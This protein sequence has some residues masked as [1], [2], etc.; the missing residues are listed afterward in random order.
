MVCLNQLSYLTVAAK[1]GKALKQVEIC[2]GALLGAPPERARL[3]CGMAESDLQAGPDTSDGGR[4]GESKDKKRPWAKALADLFFPH[5]T[6][7][8]WS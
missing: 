5:F 1:A 7:G 6:W 2:G 8:G 3:L 4:G